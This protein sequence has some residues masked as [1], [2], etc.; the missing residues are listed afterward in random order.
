LIAHTL[1]TIPVAIDLIITTEE[2]QSYK[3]G[4]A[5]FL[6]FQD[7][8]AATKRNWVHVAQSYFHDTTPIHE[9]GIFTVWINR[10][11]SADSAPLATVTLHDLTRLPDTLEQ[12]VPARRET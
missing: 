5:H 3:P 8:T 1:S 7:T 6:R 2:V 10:G 4:L 11:G 12:L 9:L